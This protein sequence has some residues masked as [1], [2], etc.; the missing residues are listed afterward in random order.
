MR[1]AA[2]RRGEVPGEACTLMWRANES[3]RQAALCALME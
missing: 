3:W 2:R 1:L